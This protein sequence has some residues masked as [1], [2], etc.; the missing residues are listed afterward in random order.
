[1]TR[2]IGYCVVGHHI[3]YVEPTAL[4]LEEARETGGVVKGVCDSCQR[5]MDGETAAETP[6]CPW[7]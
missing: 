5:E 2:I 7:K 4:A 1:M 6:V 3:R